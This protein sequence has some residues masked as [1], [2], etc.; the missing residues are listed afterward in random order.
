MP[1]SAMIFSSAARRRH[2]RLGAF[3]DGKD[4]LPK[5]HAGA[6]PLEF[7]LARAR[8]AA[9]AERILGA[10]AT[11]RTAF[12]LQWS[13]GRAPGTAPEMLFSFRLPRFGLPRFGLTSF[14]LLSF[15][16]LS[17]RLHSFRLLSFRLLSFRLLSFKSLR[18]APTQNGSL[19]AY[20][21]RTGLFARVLVLSARAQGAR[22]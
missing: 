22:R 16:L 5:T 21:M 8:T 20:M 17:F 7:V 14:R 15:R 18:Q 13:D 19:P 10:P 1:S 11:P 2:A 6:V 3:T 12:G 4:A 9:C